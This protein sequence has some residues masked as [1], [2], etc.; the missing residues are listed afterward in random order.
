M[1]PESAPEAEFQGEV[2]YVSTIG[3]TDNN[4]IV[5]Y[6]VLVKYTSSDTRLRTAMNVGISFISKQIK[7]VMVAP[8]KAVFANNNVPTVRLKDGTLRPVVTGLSDGKITEIISGIEVG[9]TILIT[10]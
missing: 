8:I 4:G 3:D 6:K 1:I 5:T 9:E 2:Y 7:D 10:N